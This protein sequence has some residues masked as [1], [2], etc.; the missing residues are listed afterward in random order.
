MGKLLAFLGAL[1]FAIPLHA[2]RLVSLVTSAPPVHFYVGLGKRRA[3]TAAER[4]RLK[5][6][7]LFQAPF[8]FGGTQDAPTLEVEVE[9]LGGAKFEGYVQ[10]VVLREMTIGSGSGNGSPVQALA[11]QA[12]A[13]RTYALGN[14]GQAR[15]SW[16]LLCSKPSVQ[17]RLC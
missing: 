15:T 7:S 10:G 6:D 16:P 13:A 1:L 4:L 14:V 8:E 9:D 2:E 3:L 11:A 5:S 12:A 17:E